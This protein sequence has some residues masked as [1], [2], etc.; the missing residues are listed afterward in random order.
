LRDKKGSLI[1]KWGAYF[2][3]DDAAASSVTVDPST[4]W[5]TVVACVETWKS[6]LLGATPGSEVSVGNLV[7]TVKPNV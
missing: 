1:D 7:V 5:T 2:K 6:K 3:V 4:G